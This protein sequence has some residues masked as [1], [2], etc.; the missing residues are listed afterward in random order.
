[1]NIYNVSNTKALQVSQVATLNRTYQW[2]A[3]GVL[4]TFFVAYFTYGS[5]TFL[6][7]L[8]SSR[9]SFIG[10]IIFEVFLVFVFNYTLTRMSLFSA[11]LCYLFYCAVSGIT[12]SVIFVA[13]TQESIA[14]VFLITA[15]GFAGLSSFGYLTKKDLGPIGTFCGMA[16]FGLIGFA[17]LSWF[18][19]SLQGEGIQIGYSIVGLLIFSGLTAYDTQKIKNRI[20]MESDEDNRNRI[21][22][23]GAFMLY[24]DFINLFINLLRLFGS[25]K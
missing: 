5:E 23:S 10:L 12:F 20:A 24:L 14:N 3:L 11:F 9:G 7:S 22:L 8:L 25:R 4:V 6:S 18:I 19:P 13:F 16:L 21:A 17:V 2:M 1:M 15:A